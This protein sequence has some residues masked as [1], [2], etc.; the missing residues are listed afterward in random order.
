MA[1]FVAGVGTPWAAIEK[2][3]VKAR[4]QPVVAVIAYVGAAAAEMLHFRDGDAL[5]CD[6]SDANVANASVSAHALRRIQRQGAE[7]FYVPGLHAKVITN[8]AFAWVGSTNVS[9]SSQD[10]LEASI[11][12]TG[13]DASAAHKWA[14]S[15]CT[16]DRL[17]SPE[18]I[19]RLARIPVVRRETPQ[20]PPAPPT[21]LP[22]SAR[23]LWIVETTSHVSSK[24]GRSAGR[25]RGDVRR[26]VARRPRNLTYI[27]WEGPLPED[28][29]EGQWMVD[30]RSGHPRRPA[31]IARISRHTGFTLIWLAEVETS[32][33]PRRA[34]LATAL[35]R[36][37]LPESDVLRVEGRQRVR[38]VLDLY[39]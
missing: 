14:L 28:M 29:D 30:V 10:L 24:A 27:E 7:V 23:T 34:Q 39:R 15:L 37:E 21:R 17:L 3:L 20:R 5:V 4:R 32:R 9:T 6:A 35:G 16:E 18:D 11:R 8:G 2:D 33:R 13:P 31:T 25:E 1:R 38:R 19:T 26:S 12:V 22:A 36:P